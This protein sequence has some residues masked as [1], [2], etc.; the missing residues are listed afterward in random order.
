MRTFYLQNPEVRK[1]QAVKSKSMA[2]CKGS[3][4]QFMQTIVSK[5]GVNKARVN[6][7]DFWNLRLFLIKPHT[8]Y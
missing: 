7:K 4:T 2:Q 3:L 1:G 8:Q 5:M 6:F